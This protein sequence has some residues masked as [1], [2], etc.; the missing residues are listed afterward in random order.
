MSGTSQGTD[1]ETRSKMDKVSALVELTFSG[2]TNCII[3]NYTIKWKVM[4]S[5][6]KKNRV[7]RE[8]PMGGWGDKV[9][10]TRMKS[11]MRLLTGKNN[12]FHAEGTSKK[13]HKDR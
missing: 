2:E 4:V 7:E 8:R 12:A 11:W 9:S 3:N 13:R 6:M 5:T 10:Q 1:N